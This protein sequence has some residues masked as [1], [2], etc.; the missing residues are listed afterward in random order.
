MPKRNFL[1]IPITSRVRLAKV[2]SV[3]RQRQLRVTVRLPLPQLQTVLLGRPEQEEISN[4]RLVVDQEAPEPE[5]APR[6][7]EEVLP[8]TCSERRLAEVLGRVYTV[9]SER[10]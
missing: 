7:T 3:F 1:T 4:M 6:R 8:R 9:T 10:P 2:V 5:L